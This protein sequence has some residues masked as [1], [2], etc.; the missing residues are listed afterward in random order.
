[1][2]S[3]IADDPSLRRVPVGKASSEMPVVV[4][5]SPKSPG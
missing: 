2:T 5:F 1:V 4:M 3:T